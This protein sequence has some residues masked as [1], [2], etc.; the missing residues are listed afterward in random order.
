VADRAFDSDV[1][2][3]V[4][5]YGPVGGVLTALLGLYGVSVTVVDPGRAP[6]P[7]P[8]A[9]ALD[10]EVLRTLVRLPGLDRCAD[11]AVPLRRSH[12]VGPGH[13]PLFTVRPVDSALGLSQGC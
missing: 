5:G 8:R 4:A 1:D 9:A 3:L 12:L 7:K 6:Y 10:A 2:V 13:R 11:W